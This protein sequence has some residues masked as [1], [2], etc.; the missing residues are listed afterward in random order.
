MASEEDADSLS[1][2]RRFQKIADRSF[3]RSLQAADGPMLPGEVR[4]EAAFRAWLRAV[5][6]RDAPPLALPDETALSV[7]ANDLDHAY[8]DNL[9]WQCPIWSSCCRCRDLGT[10]ECADCA[11]LASF[12]HV[13]TDCEPPESGRALK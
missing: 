13:A 6:L 4:L 2:H 12:L 3:W 8:G 10:A 7:M 1:V 9:W 5:G 11:R